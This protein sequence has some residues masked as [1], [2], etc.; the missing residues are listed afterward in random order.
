LI[1]R[2]R[3]AEKMK[4]RESGMIRCA[5]HLQYIRGHECVAASSGEC[6]GKIQAA[7]YRIGGNGGMGMKPDD[8]RTFPA[9]QH[10][11]ALQHNIGE[12]E[13]AK[14][15]GLDLEKIVTELARRSPHRHRWA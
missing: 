14:R 12:R 5:Q 11:H 6:S 7:H 3:K 8:T 15:Y 4:V 1:P 13:F 9:C 10:H 2:R